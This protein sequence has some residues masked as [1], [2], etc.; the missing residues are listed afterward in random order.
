MGIPSHPDFC[1][2]IGVRFPRSSANFIKFNL[3]DY[4]YLS[5]QNRSAGQR[6]K[7]T[8][9]IM[10][11]DLSICHKVFKMILFYRTPDSTNTDAL[12]QYI[13]NAAPDVAL[14]DM[15]LDFPKFKNMIYE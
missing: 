15:N 2:R 1:Q 11:F 14:G 6:D 8:V 7:S 12:L 5:Q 13:S 3:K 10:N 9:Q 4:R